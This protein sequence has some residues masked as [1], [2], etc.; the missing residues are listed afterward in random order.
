ML[1]F[2]NY[3]FAQFFFAAAFRLFRVS[4]LRAHRFFGG[5]LAR[6]HDLRRAGKLFTVFVYRFRA[7]VGR[8]RHG[9]LHRADCICRQNLGKFC[10]EHQFVVGNAL[11]RFLRGAADQ[12]SVSNCAERVNIGPRAD[13]ALAAVLLNRGIARVEFGG[14]SAVHH[15]GIGNHEIRNADFAV[16]AETQG[17]RR[18]PAVVNPH[19][20]QFGNGGNHR[21]QQ[22]FGLFKRQIARAAF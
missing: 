21:H 19:A 11:H 16:S 15:A 2:A 8:N 14:K 6:N 12:H 10:G 5:G 17:V 9:A 1:L 18:N 20:V 22:G 7:V 4:R 13:T 3:F